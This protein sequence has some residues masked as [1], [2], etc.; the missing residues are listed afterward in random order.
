MVYTPPRW[1]MIYEIYA[2]QCP[3]AW[4]LKIRCANFFDHKK[5]QK[6][7]NSFLIKKI[8]LLGPWG[9]WDP[10]PTSGEKAIFIQNCNWVRFCNIF[11]EKII[12]VS[13]F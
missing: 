9:P 7:K 10:G 11:K 8:C 4:H 6:K 5:T 2:V 13:G 3:Y 1:F 12:I